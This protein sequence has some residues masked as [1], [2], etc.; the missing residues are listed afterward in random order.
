MPSHRENKSCFIHQLHDCLQIDHWKARAAAEIYPMVSWRS[1][2]S[3]N[4]RGRWS[5]GPM[6][7]SEDFKR[8]R[9]AVG[10]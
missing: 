4:S 5:G 2:R 10:D 1:I 7:P 3:G 6:Q 8:C 9:M